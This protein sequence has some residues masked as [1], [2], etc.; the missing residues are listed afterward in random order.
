MQYNILMSKHHWLL[1]DIPSVWQQKSV[2]N[3][4]EETPVVHVNTT[5]SHFEVE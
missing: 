3:I 2:Q 1:R 5:F 4:E